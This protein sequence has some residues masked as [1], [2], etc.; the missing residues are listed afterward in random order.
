MRRRAFA[1]AFRRTCLALLTAAPA[2]LWALDAFAQ[3]KP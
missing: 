2:L 1:I 3:R